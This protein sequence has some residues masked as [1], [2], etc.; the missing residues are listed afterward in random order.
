MSLD[1]VQDAVSG[2]PGLFL[3]CLVAGFL[4]P[5]PEDGALVYAGIAIASGRLA[6]L[7]A[8]GVAASGL[9]FRDL[10]VFG[11]GR[12]LGEGILERPVVTRILRAERIERARALIR[13]RGRV[14]VLFGRILVGFRTPVFFVAGTMGLRLHTFALWDAIGLLAVV[15]VEVGLGYWFGAPVMDALLRAPWLIAFGVAV[16]AAM[17]FRRRRSR[18]AAGTGS[19][20]P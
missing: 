6:A 8:L 3:L 9:F 2:Y 15:P 18:A 13:S 14:A 11:L 1:S 12:G 19:H 10:I 7:P 16:G 17:W 4:A 20:A 5:V